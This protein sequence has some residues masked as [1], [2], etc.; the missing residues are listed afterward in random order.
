MTA[1]TTRNGIRV[2]LPLE[3]AYRALAGLLA[4]L[5][6]GTGMMVV[7]GWMLGIEILVRVR[8]DFNVMKFNTALCLIASG[9]GLWL[10]ANAT[11]KGRTVVSAALGLF[12][13]AVGAMSLFE[14]VLGWNLH[15]DQLF[16]NDLPWHPD[17]PRMVPQS[18]T[19][20]SFAGLFLIFN[21]A[22][23]PFSWIAPVAAFLANLTAQ[24]T[25]LNL[26]FRPN[27]GE[28]AALHTATAFFL[29]SMGM[30]LV[31]NP[32]GPL[33]PMFN[34]TAG[35]GILRRLVPAAIL[36]PLL[37]GWIYL[38][39][40][41]TGLLAPAA[42][43]V[44]MVVLYSASLVL[45][46]VWTAHSIDNVDLRL[47]AIIDSSEDA[48]LS[49]SLD[50]IILTWNSGAERLYGY[51]A[52]EAIGKSVLM[53]SPPELHEEQQAFLEQIRNGGRVEHHETVRVRQ[54][55]SR[56]DAFVS[57]SP[58]RNAVGEICGCSAIS[59]DIT[60]HR[61]AEKAL[62]ESEKAFRTLAELVPQMIWK[63]T[64]DGLA[65]YFNQ[66]WANYTGL[67]LQQSYGRGWDT[68][69]HPDDATAARNA[70]NHAVSTG[71]NY[72]IDCRLRAA[73]GKYRWFLIKGV[74]QRDAAGSVLE[75][76]GTCTDIDD[77]KQAETQIRELNRHLEQRVEERTAQLLESERQVRQKL[78]NILSP[79]GDVASLEL[80]DVLDVEL[81]QPLMDDLWSFTG[82]PVAIIDLDGKVLIGAGWQD[83][84]TRFHRVHPEA[85][86]NC[87]ESDC[88]LTTGVKPGEFKLYKCK[89]NM[90]DVVTPLMLGDRHIGN[91]FSGQF[92]FE[93]EAVDTSHFA[94]Q[95]R[96][97]GFDESI[98]LAALDRV[99]R[100]SRARMT[101]AMKM[102]SRLAGVLSQL[103]YSG[104]KL[105][106][107]MA[108]STR[109]NNELTHSS[110]ELE[111]FA[112]S[113]SH[114]LRAPLRHLDGFLT[115]LSKRTYDSLDAR[116]RHYI[117][118][119][120]E[121]SQRMG[122]LIDDLLQFSRLGRSELHKSEADLNVIIRE[123]R[124]ELEPESRGRQIAWRISDL[125]PVQADKAMLRQVLEN[126]IANALKFTRK[127]ASA[128]ISIGTTPAPDGSLVIFV[129]DNGAGFDMQYYDKLF[130]VF[131]RLHGE[132]EFEGTG[133]GLANVRRIVERH[134][135]AV[136]AEGEVGKGAAFYFSLPQ[137]DIHNGVKNELT[138][139]HIAG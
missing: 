3:P 99:P 126:L 84:C 16:W 82:I 104:V 34:R 1:P 54:D 37:T 21:A 113:V 59:R 12:V 57:I 48:I 56:F 68:P 18:A 105:A 109:A 7:A 86:K 98:Y 137:Q 73:N 65:V 128:E 22:R 15:I 131:Q 78:D 102:Y 10:M 108:D 2:P 38:E 130:Q 134:G 94:A 67:T 117:D 127:C 31:P 87:L 41:T 81:V 9:C 101:A 92:L 55:G 72:R 77:L 110:K 93:N 35:G 27:K 71:E 63:C 62:D 36:L 76:F 121:A 66:Q 5:S 133:I 43:I 46:T 26:V 114:D 47:A 4:I 100:I 135:G 118:C 112:Y 13:L 120:L 79:E 119:T 51:S 17:L 91:L 70:W 29:L 96:T 8:P 106:R 20:F 53:L 111:G 129:K 115:L 107:A 60:D 23:R 52:I 24:V 103:G 83:I 39:A 85:C 95:A 45:I 64:P 11:A 49:Q 132:D 138:E 6:A 74:P 124:N 88:R 30:L 122:R 25:I 14:S 90:W 50:G 116:A 28:G 40:T 19:F 61:R 33:A 42:G 44:A 125:P 97:Y 139:T 58:V 75:W 69:F 136:W 89:N 80:H 123:I 32:R